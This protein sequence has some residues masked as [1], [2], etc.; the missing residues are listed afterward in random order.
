MLLPGCQLSFG[1]FTRKRLALDIRNVLSD[2]GPQAVEAA[3]F[4]FTLIPGPVLRLGGFLV[5]FAHI[6][7]GNQ[8]NYNERD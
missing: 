5:L 4:C 2:S 8:N 1:G 3:A 6:A 7:L